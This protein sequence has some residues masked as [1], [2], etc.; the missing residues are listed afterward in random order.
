MSSN[1]MIKKVFEGFAL[2]SNKKVVAAAAAVSK[3]GS[4][5]SKEGAINLIL[6]GGS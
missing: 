5:N 4:S 3:I 2:P 1:K 6:S